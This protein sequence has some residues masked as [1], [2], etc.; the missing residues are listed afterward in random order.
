MKKGTRKLQRF[1]QFSSEEEIGIDVEK[2]NKLIDMST[3]ILSEIVEIIKHGE[4][5]VTSVE[6]VDRIKEAMFNLNTLRIMY[7]PHIKDQLR[8]KK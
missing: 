6:M 8:R 1:E 3:P 5:R 7:D 4:H 2:L